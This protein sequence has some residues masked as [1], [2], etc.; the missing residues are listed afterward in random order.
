MAAGRLRR[1][2]ALLAVAATGCGAKTESPPAAPSSLMAS[3]FDCDMG[4]ALNVDAEPDYTADYLERWSTHDGCDVRLDYVMTRVEGCF[5]GVDDLLIGWPVGG[6]HSK[7]GDYRIYL[8]DPGRVTANGVGF[9]PDTTLPDAARDTGL[10]WD[11]YSLWLIPED[12]E[13][14][15]LQAL[16]HTER[17]PIQ[18]PEFGC[19]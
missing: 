9:E 4:S 7:P 2:L 15:W 12:D 3:A 13:A 14:V 19:G 11:G 18:D 17:W 10:R 6:T 8:R 16:D 5:N 1:V